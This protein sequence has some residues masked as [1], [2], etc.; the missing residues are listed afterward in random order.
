MATASMA[1]ASM[2]TASMAAAAMKA[3]GLLSGRATQLEMRQLRGSETSKGAGRR[4][5]PVT[6]A[7][8]CLGPSLPRPTASVVAEAGPGPR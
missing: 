1:A 4:R 3:D 2:A 6:G 7:G 5:L 8:S